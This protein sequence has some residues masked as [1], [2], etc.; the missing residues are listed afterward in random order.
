ME[1]NTYKVSGIDIAG[2][3]DL[4][5]GHPPPKDMSLGEVLANIFDKNPQI[6]HLIERELR[7]T[8]PDR[9]YPMET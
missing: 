6:Y 3:Y 9:H 8:N 1:K 5:H 4:L 2:W 7:F